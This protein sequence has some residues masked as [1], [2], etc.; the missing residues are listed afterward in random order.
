MEGWWLIIGNSETNTLYAIKKVALTKPTLQAT[1]DFE[2]RFPSLIYFA[3]F[4]LLFLMN[5][6]L[7]AP[8]ASELNASLYLMSDS[9]V[10]C[11]QEF[12]LRARIQAGDAMDTAQ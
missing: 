12:E 10:G 4:E 2:V 7:Q 3:L 1:L 9:F 8:A 6:F 11:D 5:L